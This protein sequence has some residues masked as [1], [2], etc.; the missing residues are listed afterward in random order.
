MFVIGLT[1]G[2]GT[3]KTEVARV[4]KELGAVV[5]ESDRVAHLLYEPGTKAHRAI[6]E[7]FGGGVVDDTGVI[8]RKS[9]GEIVFADT[10]KRLELEEIVWPAAKQWIADRL[11]NE[12]R[13]GT[14][15]VVIEVPKLYDAGWDDLVDTVWTVESPGAVIS[16]RVVARSGIDELAVEAIVAAQLTREDREAKADLVIENDKTIKDLRNQ[17]STLWEA[18]PM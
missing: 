17:I 5:I 8:N 11:E 15:V 10:V 2:I 13:R 12:E 14:Q 16:Q 18:I 6:V 9:L 1:G 7:R 3:G 4:L